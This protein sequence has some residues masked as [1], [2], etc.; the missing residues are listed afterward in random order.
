MPIDVDPDERLAD[1]AR[2]TVDVARERGTR[3]VTLRAVAERLGRSTAYITN[4]VPSRAHLMANALDHA[5]TQWDLE[6][7]EHLG[8]LVGV[9]RLAALSRWMCTS[10]PEENV[11]RSLWIE[12]I[13]DVRGANLRAYEVVRSVTDATYGKFLDGAGHVEAGGESV[14]R[15]TAAH[16][17]DIL[18]LYCRGYE[19]KAVED[20]DVWTDA[21]VQASLEVL[22]RT[23]VFADAV[24]STR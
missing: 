2:A 5:R 19:V 15:E 6:R 9:E 8:D 22:L 1:I 13:A 16:I 3:S 21:R 20:P 18:Y 12:V 4:F 10:S 14:D 17:A 24:P 7:L 23:L 11:L